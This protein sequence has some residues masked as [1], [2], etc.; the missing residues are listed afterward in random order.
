MIT[1]GFFIVKINFQ[2]IKSLK[3]AIRNLLYED[4]L[5]FLKIYWVYTRSYEY[6]WRYM[7]GKF[8]WGLRQ[9]KIPQ[10]SST[11]SC[12]PM[13]WNLGRLIFYRNPIAVSTIFYTNIFVWEICFCN[14]TRSHHR[15]KV[16]KLSTPF[17]AFKTE[18]S[19]F[20]HWNVIRG[21]KM[22]PLE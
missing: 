19:L 20:L 6:Q 18:L 1:S 7:L 3:S 11:F 2:T 17:G 4:E 12:I 13:K 22:D 21:K 15:T 9:K 10:K 8:K 5:F 16:T 14:N